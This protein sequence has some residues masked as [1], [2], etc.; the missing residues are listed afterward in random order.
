MVSISLLNIQVTIKLFVT[1]KQN[2]HFIMPVL[3]HYEIMNVSLIIIESIPH[4]QC[5]FSFVCILQY[6]HYASICDPDM[7]PMIALLTWNI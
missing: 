5:S 4:V 3:E 6:S 7:S 2:V 1:L